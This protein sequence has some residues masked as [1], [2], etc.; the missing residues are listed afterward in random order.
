MNIESTRK[1]SLQI[2]KR[3]SLFYNTLQVFIRRR[4]GL[5]QNQRLPTIQIE[6]PRLKIDETHFGK[7]KQIVGLTPDESSVPL[8]YPLTL[9]FALNV[10]ILSHKSFPLSIFRMLNIRNHI[11]QHQ[12]INL[13]DT[14]HLSCTLN[15]Q[16]VVP[17]GLELDIF[18][19]IKREEKVVWECVNTYYFRGQFGSSQYRNAKFEMTELTDSNR[20]GKFFIPDKSGFPFAKISGDPNGLHYMGFYSRLLGYK[21]AFV[22]PI[23]VLVKSLNRIAPLQYKKSCRLDVLIK[24]PVYYNRNLFLMGNVREDFQR[25]NL[26]CEGNS[27]PCICT[28]LTDFELQHENIQKETI[29]EFNAQNLFHK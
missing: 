6:W 23:L 28:E 9:A 1:I 21:G 13:A 17:T 11:I 16:R 10:S 8:L 22:Q 4:K 2:N 25:F 20:L 14:L 3:P 15:E 29:E 24:G 5:K 7:F 19:T 27:R 26:F 18:V 12:P